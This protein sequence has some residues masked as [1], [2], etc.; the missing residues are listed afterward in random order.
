MAEDAA[1]SSEL[2]MLLGISRRICSEPTSE[3]LFQTILEDAVALIGADGGT[4]YVYD[5][6]T[7]SLAF[8]FVLSSNPEVA[9]RLKGLTLARGVGIVGTVAA[10]LVTDLVADTRHDARLA[11]DIDRKTGFETRS[12]LTVPLHFFDD[13]SQ[14][15]TLVGVLQLVN[16]KSGA[17]TESDVQ[18]MEAFGGF[19]AALL[20]RAN[21]FQR[22]RRQFVGTIASLA[23]AVDAKD[24]YTHGHSQRVAAYSVALGAGLALSRAQLFS[25]RVSSLLHDIGKIAVPDAILQKQTRLTDDEYARIK[26]HSQEG[27]RILKPVNMNDEVYEGILHHHEKWDGSGYPDRRKGTDIPLFGRIVAFGDAFDT[28]TT[29]RPYKKAHGFEEAR[30]IILHDAGTHFDPD[31]AARFC[32]L[33]LESIPNTPSP[34]GAESSPEPS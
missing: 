14:S 8:K 4:I 34:F 33:P 31:L 19:A 11:R 2:A 18:T 25:L 28:I 9:N 15:R 7:D 29:E 23:E 12:M 5:S 22:I 30:R 17:F 27:V 1:P 16:K 6:A 24:P 10:T 21:L 20:T 13:E 3:A 32:A 26:C